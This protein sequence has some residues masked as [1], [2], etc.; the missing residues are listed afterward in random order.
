MSAQPTG[1]EFRFEKRRTDAVVTL[2][3]GQAVRGSFFVSYGSARHTGPERV[4][5]LLNSEP[6]FFPF[7]IHDDRGD[8]TALYHRTH[9]VS[10]SLA[11]NEASLDPGYDVATR[12]VV[13]ILLST[14][15]RV[16]G[17]VRVYRPEGRDRLSDWARQADVFRYVE[18]GDRTLVV[19]AA[20][21]VE[22]TEVA[23]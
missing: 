3:S 18:A 12:R 17:A 11:D 7:E 5:D 1:S 14:G 10:V 6:G 9:V 16:V 2:S 8:R 21:I 23:E 22:V 4:G 15:E 13:S 20:H 19:N